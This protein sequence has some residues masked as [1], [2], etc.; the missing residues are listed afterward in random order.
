MVPIGG[1]TDA[2][3]CAWAPLFCQEGEEIFGDFVY[4]GL[5]G[6]DFLCKGLLLFQCLL[7]FAGS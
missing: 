7:V 3:D 2:S 4:L 6:G 1:M 5:L